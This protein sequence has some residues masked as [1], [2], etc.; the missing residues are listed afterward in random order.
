MKGFVKKSFVFVL[1][2][3]ALSC[4]NMLT[5][6]CDEKEESSLPDGYIE[7]K[8]DTKNDFS[9]MALPQAFADGVYYR[10]KIY[11]SG[12]ET[13]CVVYSKYQTTL[14][15][16][17]PA[18]DWT[19][20]SVAKLDM[21]CPTADQINTDSDGNT[22]LQK[23]T[24]DD[25][26]LDPCMTG[27]QDFNL[28]ANT[29]VFNHTINLA[30]AGT[31]VGGTIKLPVTVGG[32]GIKSCI[33]V[34][35]SAGSDASKYIKAEVTDAGEIFVLSTAPFSD[36]VVFY[37]FKDSVSEYLSDLNEQIKKAALIY[38]DSITVFARTTTECWLGIDGTEKTVDLEQLQNNTNYVSSDGNDTYGGSR[39]KPLKTVAQALA[40][41]QGDGTVYILS[42]PGD[43]ESSTLTIDKNITIESL[44]SSKITLPTN[45]E[46]KDGVEVTI[47]G[48]SKGIAFSKSSG[49]ATTGI[50]VGENSRLVLD[51]VEVSGWQN[52]LVADKACT[53][54]LKNSSAVKG[55]EYGIKLEHADGVLK[56]GGTEVGADQALTSDFDN[57][58]LFYKKAK[59]I[60]LLT[61]PSDSSTHDDV[62]NGL[63]SSIVS[64]GDG[65]QLVFGKSTSSGGS[66]TWNLK[67]GIEFPSVTSGTYTIKPAYSSGTIKLCRSS[68]AATTD[69]FPLVKYN[70]S[71]GEWNI[72]SVTF[73]GGTNTVDDVDVT[74][75]GQGGAF[76]LNSSHGT[77][78]FN[79]CIFQKNS[80]VYGGAVY[81]GAG[82]VNLTGC[83]IG[84]TSYV[85]SASNDGGAIYLAGAS[86]SL[87]MNSGTIS[88]NTA[89]N[90]GAIFVAHYATAEISGG[91]I[92]SNTATESGGAVYQGGNFKVSGY[93]Y[94]TP[95]N[96]VNSN[97]VYLASS[98]K[99]IEVTGA[100]SPKSNGAATG[101]A[102]TYTAAITPSTWKRGAQVLTGTLAKDYADKFKGSE[103]DWLTIKD[104]NDSD[105]VKLYTSYEIYVAGTGKASGIGTGKTSANGGL[106][107][108]AKPYASI[109]EAVEQCWD[110]SNNGNFTI[111]LSGSLTSKTDDDDEDDDAQIIPAKNTTAKTGLAKSITLTGYTGNNKDIINRNLTAV[112]SSGSGTAL[113]INNTAPVT[114]KKIKIT[115]GYTSANG[116]GINIGS[117]CTVKLADDVLV[118]GNT[119]KLGGGVYNAGTLFMYKNAI[120]G[121]AASSIPSDYNIS[122]ALTAG[123]NI[124]TGT[125]CRAGGI[126]NDLG[127]CIYLGYTE[128]SGTT[129][130]A[131]AG[132]NAFTGGIMGNYASSQGGGIY[133][134]GGKLYMNKGNISYNKTVQF[135]GGVRVSDYASMTMDD[136]SIKGNEA[137]QFGGGI[138]V[139]GYEAFTMTGGVIEANK[140]G[141]DGGAIYKTGNVTLKNSAYIP[142]GVGASTGEGMNDVYGDNFSIADLT[143]PAVC[144]DG[145]VATVTPSSYADTVK[146]I[147]NSAGYT[148]APA[149]SVIPESS[150]QTWSVS[151][152][153]GKL[154]KTTVMTSSNISSFTPTSGQKYNFVMDSTVTA[155]DM[156][157][158]LEKLCN[159]EVNTSSIKISESST[160]DL[161]KTNL[162]SFGNMTFGDS[163][164]NKLVEQTFS[165]VILPVTNC[166]S[167]LAD[168]RVRECLSGAKEFI[169]PPGSSYMY[170]ENG[171]VY[172]K[173]K[174][175]I[176]YYPASS[177]KTSYTW[178]DTVIEVGDYAFALT[179]N[180]SVMEIPNTVT[181]IGSGAFRN[182]KI[183]SLTIPAS[184]TTIK[185]TVFFGCEELTTATVDNAF[186]SHM[187][188]KW[189]RNLSTITFGSNFTIIGTECFDG[190][191]LTSVTIPSGV[192]EIGGWAFKDCTSM[193]TLTFENTSNWKS[194]VY[195]S[196]ELVGDVTPAQLNATN[197]LSTLYQYTLK[198]GN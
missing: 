189:C 112:P 97:D 34:P 126:Y 102:A 121:Y 1:S 113:T 120:V 42:Q 2:L 162:T 111:Y 60:R 51:K 104:T 26:A 163:S 63:I 115:G 41:C 94:I 172:N 116:G 147:S 175:K 52:G 123:G 54:D 179:K 30:F 188:F 131:A 132:E 105:K 11:K 136:G 103:T 176:I 20:A 39:F 66:V 139:G 48:Q 90:G 134:S 53:V 38:S 62:L 45:I 178:P 71:Y 35:D 129:P 79:K 107:T 73:E 68:T 49:T 37:F 194:Y 80:A 33:I 87:T 7:F 164:D 108:K 186:T 44:S 84:A 169:V 140:A 174:D 4:S 157:T 17:I 56:L 181:T 82:T 149:I 46:I 58:S 185:R 146:I 65:A 22:V 171:V 144:T 61:A 18:P 193:T 159:S 184:V 137:V 155:N 59:I 133:M 95:V 72:N 36:H 40:R 81:V 135:G 177:T 67:K 125:D 43:A 156:K 117:G 143:P 160:L 196:G 31:E 89:K 187:Q 69:L 47:S 127:S 170:S 16:T 23:S 101:S 154:I 12:D 130:V 124:A 93:T 161:S 150:S 173:N 98:N 195:T 118:S 191:G 3:L 75:D 6:S 158:F 152:S 198:R 88:S 141:Y 27:T 168:W 13:N 74:D 29:R 153:T 119:A 165:Q 76:Y 151:T 183:T 77:I 92:S 91:L 192:T 180:L 86:A 99:Y 14:S 100:L 106:G 83:T 19:G 32:T 8:V 167:G 114:I 148:Y 166:A 70:S 5:P 138:Y 110:S 21:Y 10:L 145:T 142:Y 64:F 78:N 28:K 190:A 50:S 55:T 24:S 57:A 9:R 122:K 182:S 128:L 109:R 96:S 197:Y 25:S 15:F 85:N